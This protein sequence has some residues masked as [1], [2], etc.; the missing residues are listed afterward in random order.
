MLLWLYMSVEYGF[1]KKEGLIKYILVSYSCPDS[2]GSLSRIWSY[3]VH[4]VGCNYKSEQGWAVIYM[5]MY[6]SI[7][8]QSTPD[9]IKV[10]T[11]S[12]NNN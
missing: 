8:D 6:G 10:T 1:L 11:F 7:I 2:K 12:M 9:I 5:S 3:F 4:C